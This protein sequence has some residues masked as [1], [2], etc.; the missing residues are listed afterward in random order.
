MLESIKV[1]RFVV[2]PGASSLLLIVTRLCPLAD[3]ACT[4]LLI[5]PIS[6]DCGLKTRGWKETEE[7]L[8]NLVNAAKVGFRAAVCTQ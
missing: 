6:S 3:T 4:S 8:Q 1:E 5:A 7:S 2:N